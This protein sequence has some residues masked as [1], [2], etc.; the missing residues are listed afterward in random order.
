MCLLFVFS[1]KKKWEPL[2]KSVSKYKLT[3][4]YVTFKKATACPLIFLTWI[5]T[6]IRWLVFFCFLKIDYAQTQNDEVWIN[7]LNCNTNS[8]IHIFWSVSAREYL[9]MA[10]LALIHCSS[11]KKGLLHKKQHFYAHLDFDHFFFVRL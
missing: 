11:D 5:W 8:Y 4:I 3:K 1:E 2:F 9:L 10:S 7:L 6:W